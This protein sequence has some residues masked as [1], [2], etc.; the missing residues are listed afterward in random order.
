MTADQRF[1]G[2]RPDVLVFATDRLAADVS[3]A[4]PILANL[5]VATTGTDADFVVK[6]IDVYPND[7]PDPIPNPT[8]VKMGGYQQL[9]RGDVMPGRFRN[10]FEKPEALTSGMPTEVKFTLPDVYHTFRSGHRIMIQ[11]QSSWYPLVDRNPQTFMEISRANA[12]DYC[13]AQQRLYHTRE[14]P[15]HVTFLVVP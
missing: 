1:A 12:S 13:K 15:S 14:L 6:V 7:F 5:F 3:I 9:V 2:R 11:V 8:G 4:G 10:S